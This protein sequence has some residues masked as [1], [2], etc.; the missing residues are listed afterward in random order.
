MQ[1]PSNAA[2]FLVLH[3]HQVSGK[4]TQGDCALVDF[5][6]QFFACFL[7]LRSAR[8]GLVKKTFAFGFLPLA[9]RQVIK[10][11]HDADNLAILWISDR[12]DVDRDMYPTPIWSPDNDFF[13]MHGG[14][15]A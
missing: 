15:S 3:V 1:F 13:F 2:T 10:V 5:G 14:P 11:I 8:L 12:I 6:F 9:F 7:K 4:V